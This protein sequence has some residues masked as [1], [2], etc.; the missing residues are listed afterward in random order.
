MVQ[1]I[2][3][4]TVV[5]VL[6]VL[7]FTSSQ[8]S[9]NWA[10]AAKALAPVR[11]FSEQKIVLLHLHNQARFFS[12]LGALTLSN[13]ARYA[14]RHG[15]ELVYST[16]QGNSGL[17]KPS[18]CDSPEATIAPSF[19]MFPSETEPCLTPD[20][21]FQIDRRAPTFG[22]IK[23]ALAACRTRPDYWML[24]T[25]ADA[26]VVNQSIPIESI[27]D[28]RYDIILT[29]DW[30]MINA[31]MILFKCSSWTQKF[32]QRVYDAREFDSARALDQ[33]AFQHFFDT[34]PDMSSHLKRIPKY[35]MNVYVEE[36]RPGDFLLH[37]AGKLYEATT[38]G[39]TAIAHQFDILSM[40]DD[41]QD[42]D[43]FFQGQYFL[44]AYSGT[45][46]HREGGH[47]CK[48]ED[49]RRLKLKEPLLAMSYP[50]RYRHV[51]LRYYWLKKW[52]DHYDTKNWNN[53]GRVSFDPSGNLAGNE[54]GSNC[55][56]KSNQAGLDYS[57]NL[58]DEL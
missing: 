3:V 34:E 8:G 19:I 11:S 47:E 26:M 50:Y 12:E 31:G 43:A 9:G 57:E 41:I 53:D 1:K 13:K 30:L 44:N 42:I 55:R 17:W 2:W 7:S 29:V 18:T 20:Q 32:L 37:M 40:V 52:H 46:D 45:C 16:P 28:D 36:Y 39:A 22:K 33:S 23:L 35:A 51:G 14:S 24:W 49:P 6:I 54:S 5:L 48:P 56:A 58:H 10:L 25:D 38:A 15:Y 4:S 21:S 27:I